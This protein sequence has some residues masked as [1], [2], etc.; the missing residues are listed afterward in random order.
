MTLTTALSPHP[1]VAEFEQSRAGDQLAAVARDMAS[2]V[3][4]PDIQATEVSDNMPADSS[5]TEEPFASSAVYGLCKE[6]R[7]WRDKNR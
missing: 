5:L 7:L 4:D 1:R 6:T 3:T 2:T